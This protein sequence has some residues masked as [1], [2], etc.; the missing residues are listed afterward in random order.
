MT[1]PRT[2]RVSLF[3]RMAEFP[4]DPGVWADFVATYGPTVVQWCRRYGLQDCD[5]H[6]VAQDVL[7]R[8]WRQAADFRYDPARRLRGYL[9]RM[10]L[11][12]V[13][14][15]SDSRRADR[16][17]TGDDAV[18]SLLSSLPARE[19][20]ARRIEETFD[21][22]MLALA[23]SRVEARVLPRTWQAFRMLALERCCGE[24][25]A[26]TLGMDVNNAYRAKS[27][28]QRMIREVIGDLGRSR[29]GSG[30]TAS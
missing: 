13:S 14:D 1:S 30:T 12:A 23:M 7:V 11:S 20:L 3:A 19:D 18:Q 15:W 9:R 17:G 2:T 21:T 5:A 22:E 29:D 8:F 26:S 28:V 4:G 27:Q 6:D 24:E 16:L 10:V 25:V